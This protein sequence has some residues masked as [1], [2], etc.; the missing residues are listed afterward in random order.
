MMLAMARILQL[1]SCLRMLQ[2]SLLSL[3][4][5]EVVLLHHHYLLVF[6]DAPTNALLADCARTCSRTS[7][8][9]VHQRCQAG[10]QDQETS[11]K[12]PELSAP[13]YRK[14][15]CQRQ[16]LLQAFQTKMGC[17]WPSRSGP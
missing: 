15:V 1:G 12:P 8:H 3:R 11:L 16:T 14:S 17:G 6:W 9:A 10:M 4:E 13:V 7:G 2:V 5:E